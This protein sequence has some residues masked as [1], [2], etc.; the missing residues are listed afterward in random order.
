M[1]FFFFFLKKKVL[2]SSL[3]SCILSSLLKCEV[4]S[5][6]KKVKKLCISF[7]L[8]CSIIPAVQHQGEDQVNRRRTQLGHE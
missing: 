7:A 4:K 1:N 5:L 3:H 8:Y 2:F 6:E